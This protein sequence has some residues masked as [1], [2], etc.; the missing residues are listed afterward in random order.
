MSPMHHGTVA[1]NAEVVKILIANG[2]DANLV[3]KFS[4]S[5]NLMWEPVKLSDN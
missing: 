5:A 1:G 4:D 3:I 2:G